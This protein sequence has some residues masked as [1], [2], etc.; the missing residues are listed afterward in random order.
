MNFYEKDRAIGRYLHIIRDSP[1][2]PVIFDSK[3]TV[4]S[5]PP[6]INGDHSK[7]STKTRNIFIEVT[8][9]DK[10]KLEIVINILVTMFSLYTEEPFT[11]EPVKI[12]SKY[13][14]TRQV[15]DLTPRETEAEVSYINSCTGLKLSAED[16]CKLLSRMAYT[17]TPSKSSKNLLDVIIPPTR[18]DVLHQCDVM[19]DVAVAYGFNSLPRVFRGTPTAFAQPLPV[20]KLSDIFRDQAAMAGWLE[21]MPLVLCS[22]DENFAFLNRKDSGNEAIKLANPKTAEYQ[23]VRTT[24]LPGMLKTIRENQ[25][26]SLP[27]KVFEVGD[28]AYKDE[29]LERK[30]KNERHFA[31]AWYGKTSGF[32]VIHGMLDLIMLKLN[33]VFIP[34]EEDRKGPAK[35]HYAYWIEAVDGQLLP[36]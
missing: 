12:V 17:A 8:G 28:I 1:V 30:T 33:C 2:Y 27:L 24:L 34:N 16:M 5:L 29:S 7:I 3:R 31:A 4:C 19:E 25:S 18:A 36:V 15:P 21:V 11:V 20:N 6:I 13:N 35:Y 14:E 32:E 23:V 26:H 22:H 10:T 9:T